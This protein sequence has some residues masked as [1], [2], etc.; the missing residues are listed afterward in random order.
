MRTALI[1]V[2]A[3]FSLTTFAQSDYL[4]YKKIEADE[5][6]Q[7]GRYWD[8][9]FL[10]RNLAKTPDFQGDYTIE[11]QIK[12]SSRAMFHWKKTEDYRAFQQYETAKSHMKE[13]LVL[14][15]YDPHRGLLPVLTLE[16]ANQM[17]RRAIASRTEEGAADYL[18]RALG[19]YN[20]ALEEGLK[21]E[22]VFSFIRQVES[23]LEKN[24]YASKIK[25]P[26]TYDINYQK[27]K[28]EKARTIEILNKENNPL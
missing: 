8:A 7:A 16:L 21:D 6:Y 27:D 23:A 13:L 15:P 10:Y 4:K 18:N 1:A 14:N 20:L 9:F 26:T 17:K 19:F 24:P 12:N 2:F 11:D 5:Y 3:L 25:Q 22:M 28:V